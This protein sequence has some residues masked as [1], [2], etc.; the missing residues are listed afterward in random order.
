MQCNDHATRASRCIV[1][2]MA[3]ARDPIPALKQRVADEILILTKGWTQA[4]AAALIHTRQPRF[5]ELRAGRL[6]RYSLERLL[7]YLHRLGR[8]IEIVTRQARVTMLDHSLVD[9]REGP[10]F[11]RREA[12]ALLAANASAHT[13]AQAAGVERSTSQNARPNDSYDD[14]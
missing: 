4:N 8:G 11:P 13:A 6:E 9:K 1:S 3:N 7:R 10:R 2:P 14:L 12:L 5:S